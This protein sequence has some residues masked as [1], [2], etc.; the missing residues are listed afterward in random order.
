MLK[1]VREI[2]GDMADK[3][4]REAYERMAPRSETPMAEE[5]EQSTASD[6]THDW[7][8]NE[9]RNHSPDAMQKAMAKALLELTG[10]Q[11][12]VH[13]MRVDFAPK[14]AGINAGSAGSAELLLRV[15]PPPWRPTADEKKLPF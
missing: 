15:S 5:H 7:W 11:Y 8:G 6:D 12:D 1:H 4:D 10:M 14:W 13:V 3:L 2:M 9:L